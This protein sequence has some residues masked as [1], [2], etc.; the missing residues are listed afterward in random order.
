MPTRHGPIPKLVFFADAMQHVC[1]LA[2]VLQQPRGHAILLGVGGSG[3]RTVARLAA[4]ISACELLTLACSSASTHREFREEL[5]GVFDAAGA[6][7]HRVCL[8][9][10]EAQ[11]Q[12]PAC[13]EDISC[14]LNGAEVPRL[15]SA[16]E[17]N[18]AFKKMQ[19][20]FH[21]N[22]VPAVQSAMHAALMQR[23]RDNIHVVLAMSPTS[24]AFRTKCTDFPALLNCCTMDWFAPWPAT[25]LTAVAQQALSRSNSV[26][27]A[28]G[29]TVAEV[30]AEMHLAV[31]AYTERYRRETT[32]RVY[33][34]P[35]S[36][37]HLAQHFVQLEARQRARLHGDLQRVV[38]GLAKLRE[39]KAAVVDMETALQA[40]FRCIVQHSLCGP[41]RR[42]ADAA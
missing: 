39:S 42:F 23:A 31:D 12:S 13:M 10:T 6:D 16:D 28:V 33:V 25:A 2:R 11:L 3:K 19:D 17:C 8:Y 32:R 4:S 5:K 40:C 7:G 26:V 9:L 14:V 36:F 27:R 29:S 38:T 21:E 34:T 41:H 15:L 1:R 20:H 35:Q 37:L 30:A 22:D 18:A 24:A